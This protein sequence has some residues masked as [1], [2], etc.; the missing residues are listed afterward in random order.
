MLTTGTPPVNPA[1]LPPA[2]RAAFYQ[3]QLN[4]T[5]TEMKK[6]NAGLP[7]TEEGRDIRTAI[8]S[9]IR[10]LVEDIQTLNP[11]KVLRT[12]TVQVK[13]GKFHK[14]GG[15]SFVTPRSTEAAAESEAA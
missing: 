9:A 15:F 1:S 3:A 13:N 5:K 8:E 12:L 6:A 14:V 11:E 2:Q 7:D 4:A 10:T